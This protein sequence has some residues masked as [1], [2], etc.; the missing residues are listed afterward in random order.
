MTCLLAFLDGAPDPDRQALFE[1]GLEQDMVNA[2]RRG[3][4]LDIFVRTAGDEYN[5]RVDVAFSQAAREID[6]VH[7]GHLVIDHETIYLGCSDPVQQRSPTPKRPDV[8]SVGFKQ[9]SK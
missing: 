1:V 5:G 9:E 2:R 3:F 7:V 8:E 4:F 6:A